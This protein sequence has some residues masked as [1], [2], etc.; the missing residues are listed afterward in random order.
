[1][2]RS[3]RGCSGLGERGRARRA[4]SGSEPAGARGAGGRGWG[5]AGMASKLAACAGASVAAVGRA[6]AAG[7]SRAL[8][9][10]ATCV[11]KAPSGTLECEEAGQFV[12][13]G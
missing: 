8:S 10:T 5:R 13:D 9:L 6:L 3:G 4:R 7:S 12:R 11:E 1:M 2:G